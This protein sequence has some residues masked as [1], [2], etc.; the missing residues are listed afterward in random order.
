MCIGI[1]HKQNL[2]KK[3]IDV[4]VRDSDPYLDTCP[5]CASIC[6]NKPQSSSQSL[7]VCR[8]PRY[9]SPELYLLGWKTLIMSPAHW[10]PHS[11]QC[12]LFISD[13]THHFRVSPLHITAPHYIRVISFNSESPPSQQNRLY[14]NSITTSIT[15]CPLTSNQSLPITAETPP[16]HN[17]VPLS[18]QT[19]PPITTEPPHHKRTYPH[20]KVSPQSQQSP[21][22]S[23][24]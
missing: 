9:P 16:H 22:I 14:H 24:S 5:H 4:P 15:E 12:F 3:K 23:L 2:N 19:V 10:C 8:I 1:S 13:S 6:V 18:Q 7:K 21:S 17:I 11:H 20:N